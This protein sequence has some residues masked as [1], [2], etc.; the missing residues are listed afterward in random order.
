MEQKEQEDL[1][2]PRCVECHSE[3][4]I[5]ICK[6]VIEYTLF[7]PD[8]DKNWVMIDEAINGEILH[9]TYKCRDCGREHTLQEIE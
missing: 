6:E 3:D 8:T 4:I 2:H 5:A 7:V 1:A 9:T